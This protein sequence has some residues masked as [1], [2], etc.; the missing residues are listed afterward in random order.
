MSVL[1]VWLAVAVPGLVLAFAL[2]YGRSRVRTLLGYLA[3]AVT[4][5]IVV[6]VDR[7]SGTLIGGIAALLYGAGRGGQAEAEGE[8]TSTIA[9][10]DTVRRTARFRR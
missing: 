8:D 1:Q 6:M 2:F 10:P 9:V 3:L 7:A 5:G 4:F